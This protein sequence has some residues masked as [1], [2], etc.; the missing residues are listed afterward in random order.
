M[1]CRIFRCSF[2]GNDTAPGVRPVTA[3][4]NT[5]KILSARESRI[6]A[7]CVTDSTVCG[8]QPLGSADSD[9]PEMLHDGFSGTARRYNV[10]MYLC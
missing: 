3:L 10:Q 9:L 6:L 2:Y 4:E 8:Q 7:I 1:L 5:S